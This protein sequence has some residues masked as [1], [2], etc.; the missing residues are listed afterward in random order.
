MAGKLIYGVPINLIDHF[1]SSF[2]SK[3]EEKEDGNFRDGETNSKKK[4]AVETL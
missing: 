1:I 3:T 2:L 4:F